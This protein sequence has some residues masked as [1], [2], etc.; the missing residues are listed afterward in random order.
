MTE[1]EKSEIKRLRDEGLTYQE[2][3]NK[4]GVTKQCIQQLCKRMGSPIYMK[5]ISKIK[6]PQIRNFL[7]ENRMGI[8][9]MNEIV[10]KGK[11]Q[12]YLRDRLSGRVCISLED[13]Q[14]IAKFVGLSIEQCFCTDEL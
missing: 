3:G 5:A 6:Y 8:G 2:I 1:D 12:H 10:F 4:F 11:R 14:K 7:F 13:A 9:E